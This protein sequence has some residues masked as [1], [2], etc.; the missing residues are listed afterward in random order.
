MGTSRLV[1][2]TPKIGR[3]RID[4]FRCKL[5]SAHGPHGRAIQ[6]WLRHTL[7]NRFA[8]CRIA[9]VAPQPFAR[10]ETRAERGTTGV[11][12][13]AASASRAAHLAVINLVP[14]CDHFT[15]STL[16]NCAA[17]SSF[18]RRIGTSA[19]RWICSRAFDLPGR[20]RCARTRR[21]A[22]SG[23][24]TPAI[25]NPIDSPGYIIRD[26]ERTIR[27]HGQSART[28]LG[29]LRRFHLTCESVGK[30]LALASGPIS[31]ERLKNY[32]IAA[33][34]IGCAIPR[35]MEGDEYSVGVALRK[36][37]LVIMHHSIRRPMS[38]KGG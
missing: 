19:F 38:G 14:E 18:T 10:G 32:V 29:A 3:H 12:T 4:L 6:L 35:A 1:V 9:T 16:R 2:Q 26:I 23:S 5:R 21:N 15:R 17:A 31:G 28:M 22:T 27:T 25:H 24:C 7:G 33:L 13:V 11:L 30:N 36:L 20:R 8:D 34:G 37:L